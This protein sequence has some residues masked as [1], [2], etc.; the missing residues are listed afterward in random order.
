MRRRRA[1]ALVAAAALAAGMGLV[2][3][4]AA[5]A[6]TCPTV[7]PTGELT[8]AP[9]PGVDWSGCA[10]Y[11]LVGSTVVGASLLDADMTNANLSGADLWNV[12]T[13]QTQLAGADL[14]GASFD[15]AMITDT[16]L[17][18]ADL[19]GADLRKASL[20]SVT[21]SSADF[22]GALLDGVTMNGTSGTPLGLPA[23]WT[24]KYGNIWGPYVRVGKVNAQ[25]SWNDGDLSGID[26]SHATLTNVLFARSDVEGMDLS[27]ATFHRFGIVLAT[28]A[29]AALPPGYA[30]VDG[31]LVGP[32]VSFVGT[33]VAGID[34]HGRDLHDSNFYGADL[35]GADLSGADLRSTTFRD[36]VLVDADLTGADLSGADLL[37]ADL[38][39]ATTDGVVWTGAMC[40]D[41]NGAADHDHG[42]CT[43]PLDTA[44]PT[45]S[46]AALPTYS[47]TRRIPLA[48][49]ASDGN[50]LGIAQND[51]Q[52]T[53]TPSFERIPSTGWLVGARAMK[54]SSRTYV[55]FTGHRYCFRLSLTDFTSR[56]TRTVPRCTELPM[57]DRDLFTEG[58]WRRT[59]DPRW[60]AASV[61]STTSK[62]AALYVALPGPVTRAGLVAT[63]CP[64]CGAVDVLVGGRKVG[65]VSLA[66]TYAAQKI[67]LLPR[68]SARK[69]HVRVVV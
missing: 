47:L 56:T 34:L 32:S 1:A 53:F 13:G 46:M 28:G 26:L 15:G 3:T 19:S 37:G 30:F 63:T 44:A 25:S 12:E 40:P 35:T 17:S 14:S 7:S 4:P 23:G 45:G 8:P 9:S 22:T 36:A 31:N 52:L 21:V 41:A 18:D 48:W 57:D 49:T 29:P 16:N 67:L 54:G 66:G 43:E 59:N 38:T 27:S 6:A 2:A 55:A 51:L 60:L 64:G 61:S 33:D 68:F 50:G 62:G 65:R 11:T 39:G 10:L 5:G 69:A 58:R 42:D 20:E 24:E